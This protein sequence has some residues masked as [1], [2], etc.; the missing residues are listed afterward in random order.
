M[1]L[2]AKKK[3][4]WSCQHIR[5]GSGMMPNA[6]KKKYHSFVSFKQ[7]CR[8]EVKNDFVDCKDLFI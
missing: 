1:G 2:M 7:V 4:V 8:N 5:D 3:I 6:I